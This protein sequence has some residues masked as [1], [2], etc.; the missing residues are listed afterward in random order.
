MRSLTFVFA[1]CALAGCTDCDLRGCKTKSKDGRTY[2]AVTDYDPSACKPLTLDGVA[3]PHP[4]GKV[5]QIEPGGHT[6]S[7]GSGDSGISFMVPKG[8]I[9]EFSYWGP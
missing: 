4:P 9:F 1:I 3:W 6:I 7:C 8:V 2:L 5:A